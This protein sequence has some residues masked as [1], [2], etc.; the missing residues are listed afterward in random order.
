ML[1]I[2]S[3]NSGLIHWLIGGGCGWWLVGEGG[4]GVGVG[5]G[6]NHI[7]CAAI[8]TRPVFSKFRTTD[9][10][11]LTG[12]GISIVT[13]KGHGEIGLNRKR[14]ECLTVGLHS[15]YWGFF[16]MLRCSSGRGRLFA[17]LS[18]IMWCYAVCQGTCVANVLS[19]Y[20]LLIWPRCVILS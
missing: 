6:V 19:L 7:L 2:Y 11:Y 4:G 3:C 10:I 18:T 9:T 8:I 15:W 1:A 17:M 20:E 13:Y 12:E 5:V 16:S 14:T